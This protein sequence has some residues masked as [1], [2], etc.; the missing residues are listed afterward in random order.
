[1]TMTVSGSQRELAA[2]R[3]RKNKCRHAERDLFNAF[4]DERNKIQITD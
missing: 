3:E 1:M 2:G 4:W